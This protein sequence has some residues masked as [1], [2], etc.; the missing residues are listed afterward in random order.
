MNEHRYFVR[1][2]GY[3]FGCSTAFVRFPVGG[4]HAIYTLTNGED[5]ADHSSLSLVQALDFVIAGVWKEVTQAEAEALVRPKLKAG[6][7][8]MKPD[9]LEEF[10]TV[11]IDENRFVQAN[12]ETG[13][14]RPHGGVALRLIKDVP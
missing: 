10:L 2:G 14:T 3:G 12:L 11:Q 13:H 6:Q 7:R 5:E 8:W 1:H 4:G 9:T